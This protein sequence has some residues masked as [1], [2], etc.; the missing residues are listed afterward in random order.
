MQT[1]LRAGALTEQMINDFEALL[2]GT[3]R[4]FDARVAAR[5]SADRV[6]LKDY[7]RGGLPDAEEWEAAQSAAARDLAD[8]TDEEGLLVALRQ[9]LDR[10]HSDGP[11]LLVDVSAAG[12][13]V[14]SAELD[15]FGSPQ[16]RELRSVTW[17][18]LLP[19]LSAVEQ[20]L[21]FQ[22]A[23]GISGLDHRRLWQTLRA[24]MP[25]IPAGPVLV[26][27]RPAGWPV[28][29]RA[30]TM[31]AA[32]PGA[33]V[34]RVASQASEGSALERL[35]TVAGSAPLS[36]PYKLMLAHVA[37]DSGAVSAQAR[38][39]FASGQQPGASITLRLRRLPGDSDPKSLAIFAGDDL[40]NGPLAL[41]EARLPAGTGGQV[42]VALIGPGRVQVTAPL[43]AR[44]QQDATRRWTEVRSR[45]P[46]RVDVTTTPVDLVCAVHLA[47][48]VH[49]VRQRMRLVR[50]LLECLADEYPERGWLRAAAVV[51][52]DHQ[53]GLRRER[54]DVT[55]SI[56]LRRPADA[57]EWFAR[58]SEPAPVIY[59]AAA[60]VEDLLHKA[61][62]LLAGAGQGGRE[63]RLVTVTGRRPH[64]RR[65]QGST[66]RCP[67]GYDWRS[68]M[69]DL[70]RLTDGRCVLVVDRL[71]ADEEEYNE[72]KLI[73]PAGLYGIA[74]VTE[75]QIA[76][77]L[78]LLISRTQ[79]LP[80]PL[81]CD[82]DGVGG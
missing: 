79:R 32:R 63:A 20:E 28:L 21:R 48:E 39:L 37:A 62:T 64:P 38:Q 13:A 43:G 77:N 66:I 50:S 12:I 1:S 41:W 27:C 65:Q 71:P 5:V 6:A 15:R 17:A 67:F 33:E 68:T 46:S 49:E 7:I 47:G 42:Q 76:E 82:Q 74:D 29:E 69:A 53:I 16:V 35:A 24:G 52:T 78:G 9:L 44:E 8:A 56:T 30:A 26:I 4:M 58:H 25:T 22:L 36:R 18:R 14:A 3:R 19:T 40:D 80:L 73:G 51:C 61:V 10:L 45:V 60:P 11:S 31:A 57:L 75:K 2:R 54:Q 70:G 59:E 23:G 34:V 55:Q 81:P 72:L